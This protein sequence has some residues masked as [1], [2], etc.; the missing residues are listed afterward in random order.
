[1]IDSTYRAADVAATA[2]DIKVQAGVKELSAL[3]QCPLEV[4]DKLSRRVG[5]IAQ[6]IATAEG[7]LTGAGGIWTTLLDV[8]LLFGVC[9]RTILKIGHCYGYPLDR[10][11]DKAWVLGAFA[12]SLSSTRQKRTE[13][14]ARLRE[15]EEL[16]LEQTQQQVV[17]EEAAALITQIELFEDI[18]VFGAATGALLN[19]SVAHKTETTARRLFQERWLRDNGKVDSIE[20]ASDGNVPAAQGWS[21]A[22]A[23]AGYGTAYSAAFGAALPVTLACALLSPMARPIARLA[24]RRGSLVAAA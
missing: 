8:P 13:L 17:V 4:C 22:L 24:R 15:I 7:A 12:V 5:T 11:T 10:P 23:R 3:R 21:G 2:T 19:L 1:V 9:L 6:A 20:P 18:P 14:M 16:L